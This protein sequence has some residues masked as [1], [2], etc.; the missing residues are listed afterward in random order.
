[1]EQ[2]ILQFFENLRNPFLTVVS[3]FFSLMGETLPV[4]AI[5]CILYW[6]VD[7][8]L[9]EKLIV[10][11]FSSMSVNALVKGLVARP[12]P[13]VKG[14][15][16]RVELD[17]P[18]I[19]TIELEEYASFPSGHSQMSAGAFTIFGLHAKKGWLWGILIPA[20]L[21]VMLSRLYFGVHYPTDV[22]V[23]AAC[24]TA[25]AL[26]WD[27]IY[28]KHENKRFIVLAAFAALSLVFIFLSPTKSMVELSGCTI[29]AAIALPVEDKWIKFEKQKKWWHGALRAVIGLGLIA[30]VF[31]LFAIVPGH[32]HLAMK[33]FKYFSLVLVGALAAPALFK[34]FKI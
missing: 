9:G 34:K 25:F 2:Q 28:R 1:M 5:V 24:G 22:L 31:V 14:V 33:F 29:A 7:K 32:D 19:S 21:L 20:T 18:L 8:K 17:N 16:S 6:L 4:V 3:S 12:R 30:A 15:V 26:F 11:S 13:F 10:V 23:G 27:W